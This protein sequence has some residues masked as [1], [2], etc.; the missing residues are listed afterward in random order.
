MP[1]PISSITG[2]AASAMSPAIRLPGE[3]L[4]GESFSNV[5]EQAI[6]RVENY[7]ADAEKSIGRFLAGEGEDVHRVVM[8]AQQAEISLELFLQVKNKV[9]QAYQEIMRLQV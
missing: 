4:A 8:A 9:V 7:R 3:P 5:L 6:Q 2:A 1:D